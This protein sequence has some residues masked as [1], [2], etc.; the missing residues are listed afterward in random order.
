MTTALEESPEIEALE[1]L[2]SLEQRRLDE[3]ER[4]IHE[5]LNTFYDVGKALSEIRESR[6][7]RMKYATFEDY[8][9]Q[10]WGMSRRRGYEMIAA[11][12]VVDNVRNSAHELLPENE[13]QAN[14]IASIDELGQQAIWSIVVGT[15]DKDKDDKP[16]ITAGHV[17]SVV[18]VIT[19]VVRTGGLDD[20]SGEVK[21]L[22]QLIDAAVT[23]ET[24]ERMMRQK[25]HIKEH[26][27]NKAA[28]GQRKTRE[29]SDRSEVELLYQP[30]VQERLSRYIE[31]VTEFE[32][33]EWPA[34][35][36]YLRRMFQLHKAHANFQKARNLHDDCEMALDVLRRLTQDE[37][38]GFTIAAQ[39]HYD[40]LFDLGYCMSKQEYTKRMEYMS[41]DKVRMALFTSAGEDG[42]QEDRRGKLPGI[43]CLPWRKVWK[44]SVE[45]D[46]DEDA[47]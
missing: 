18:N 44:L 17:R 40:W 35:L 29:K 33:A 23:E 30:E 42:K 34:E 4:V 9:K 38:A 6:L 39:E 15:A 13:A 28:E 24:Y 11:A 46:D 43:V 19:D 1:P 8:C 20:G 47:A 21:P 36:S 5:G 45:E 10:K 37:D 2:T 12:A 26:A 22:G 25:Q 16:I 41:D 31:M 3:C 27:E 32:N 14:E 7:Y